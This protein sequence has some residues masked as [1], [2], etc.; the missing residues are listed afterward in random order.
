MSSDKRSHKV[1]SKA[2]EYRSKAEKAEQQAKLCQD[3]DARATWNEIA[4]QWRDMAEMAERPDG[5]PPQLAASFI[6]MPMKLRVY[7][8]PC[9]CTTSNGSQG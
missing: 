5:R 8:P 7:S 1:A 6:F 2:E 9:V 3:C 4:R